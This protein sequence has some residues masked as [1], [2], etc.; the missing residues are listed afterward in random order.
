MTGRTERQYRRGKS[1]LP[2]LGEDE[3]LALRLHLSRAK[4]FAIHSS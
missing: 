4:L 3:E 1:A 2:E